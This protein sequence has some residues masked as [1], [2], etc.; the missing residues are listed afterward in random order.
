MASTH[1]RSGTF[2]KDESDNDY[3]HSHEDTSD[4]NEEFASAS[5]GDDDLPW[6][7]VV[8]RSPA[9][10]R[11]SPIVPSQ[12]PIQDAPE[13]HY[14]QE[15]HSSHGHFNQSSGSSTGG[16][17]FSPQNHYHTQSQ[18]YHHSSS[19]SSLS[20]VSSSQTISRGT[21]KLRERMRQSPVPYSKIVQAYLDPT[22][23]LQSPEHVRMAWL[24]DQQETRH[25]SS[26]DDE[27]TLES[28][29]HTLQTHSTA[30]QTRTHQSQIRPQP[31]S[32]RQ[33]YAIAPHHNPPASSYL[34]TR[35]HTTETTQTAEKTA[36]IN[37]P[38]DSEERESGWGFDDEDIQEGM[39]ENNVEAQS[40]SVEV[41]TA[42]HP[43]ENNHPGFEA[44]KAIS[45]NLDE[46]I[47]DDPE[48]SWGFDEDISLP[49]ESH[50]SPLAQDAIVSQENTCPHIHN[51]HEADGADDGW[52]YDDQGI[53]IAESAIQPE[54]VEN[55]QEHID[56]T[57]TWNDTAGQSISVEEDAW[58]ND[59]QEVNISGVPTEDVQV[60]AQPPI[61][62]SVSTT[63]GHAQT[64]LGVEDDAWGD[65]SQNIDIGLD[66]YLDIP[67]EAPE[68]ELLEDA[69]AHDNNLDITTQ[70]TSGEHLES[71]PVGAVTL[72]SHQL[73]VTQRS[74]IT[75]EGTVNETSWGFN[76]DDTPETPLHE[77]V[78]HS[79]EEQHRHSN[80]SAQHV[81]T[82]FQADG[83]HLSQQEHVTLSTSFESDVHFDNHTTMDSKGQAELVIGGFDDIEENA[84]DAWGYDDPVV[85]AHEPIAEPTETAPVDPIPF[86]PIHEVAQSSI[87]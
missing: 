4:S 3:D 43:T 45:I 41:I 81:S 50:L 32:E 17:A 34:T 24:Q 61:H 52:G 83:S 29:I 30:H 36:L 8:I 69:W 10:S 57:H 54:L 18:S 28:K 55:G 59:L 1:A 60:P 16:H 64:E 20:Q 65:D 79:A 47:A 2:H 39:T 72:E 75:S 44:P 42:Q 22:T 15:H 35:T 70:D 48:A 53:E 51:I 46:T 85:E 33:V 49:A 87:E 6:E 86:E 23:Q 40:E 7:P 14:R 80:L 82:H 73:K 66:N 62:T 37:V 77:H 74:S 63:F 27:D 19:S 78:Q 26:D 67:N 5:E 21:P 68:E 56:T 9:I 11:A 58:G 12:T 71:F 38:V 25:D 76:T 84:G 13:D 31:I